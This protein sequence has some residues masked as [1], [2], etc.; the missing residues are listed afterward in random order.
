MF[1]F[2]VCLFRKHL[3]QA[4]ARVGVDVGIFEALN[5]SREPL[6]VA[7]LAQKTGAAPELLG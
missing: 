3:T 2:E 6:N 5:E 7:T 4:M 1:P